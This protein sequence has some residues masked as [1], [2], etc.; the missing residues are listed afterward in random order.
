MSPRIDAA[1]GHA[2]AD[3][4]LY[5]AIVLARVLV[6]RLIDRGQQEL[7]QPSALDGYAEPSLTELPDEQLALYGFSFD[8]GPRKPRAQASHVHPIRP[9]TS[10]TAHVPW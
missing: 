9:R 10:R 1:E 2:P 8:L 4:H 7:L 6:R 3:G 5:C